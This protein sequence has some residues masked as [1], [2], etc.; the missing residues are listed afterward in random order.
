MEA[1]VSP[2]AGS[3]IY[4]AC[5]YHPCVVTNSIEIQYKRAIPGRGADPAA[6]TKLAIALQCHTA[7]RFH[8]TK[9]PTTDQGIAAYSAVA[10]TQA[11]RSYRLG[12][13]A[14]FTTHR[15]WR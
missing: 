1:N 14:I 10:G 2:Q 9:S 5:D 8:A 12:P 3:N 6:A 13:N 4:R 7:K 15:R 11:H